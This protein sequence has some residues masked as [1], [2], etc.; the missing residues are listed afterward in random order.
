[1]RVDLFDFDPTNRRAGMGIIL[2]PKFRGTGYARKAVQLMVDYCFVHLK[3]SQ[4][5]AEVPDQNEESSKLFK[6]SGFVKTGTKLQ[7]LSNGNSFTDVHFY[8][9]LNKL[10]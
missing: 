7:W 3:L 2:L 1:M 5:Y 6:A 10:T 8:Q 9:R 4:L